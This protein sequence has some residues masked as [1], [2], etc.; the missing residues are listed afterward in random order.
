MVL[1]I[2]LGGPF[3]AALGMSWLDESLRRSI[4]GVVLAVSAAEAQVNEWAEAA[5]GWATGEDKENLVRKMKRLAAKS[6]LWLNIGGAPFQR[7]QE[8][9]DFR[10]ELVH[11]KAN[12]RELKIASGPVPGLDLS[13]KA[14]ETCQLVRKS[15]IAVADVLGLSRPK[16][17]A[18]CPPGDFRDDQL[19]SSAVVMAGVREDPDFPK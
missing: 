3:E 7:F 9:V 16:Y 13:L 18:Y 11:P 19:W 17:L 14:R 2:P 10:H 12:E 4:A 8:C 6:S 5:G 1:G 15:L